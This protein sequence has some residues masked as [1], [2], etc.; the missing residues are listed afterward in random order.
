MSRVGWPRAKPKTSTVAP[1]GGAVAAMGRGW[2]G[3]GVVYVEQHQV[4]GAQDAADVGWAVVE[5]LVADADAGAAGDDVQV[6]DD[7]GLGWPG[8]AGAGAGGFVAGAALGD[9]AQ[10]GGGDVGEDGG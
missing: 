8:E 7:L 10:D 3:W 4:G 6:C 1:G 2:G 9:D 5:L